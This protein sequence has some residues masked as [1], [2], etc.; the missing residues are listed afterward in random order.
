MTAGGEDDSLMHAFKNHLSVIIGFC[1]L[2][3]HDLPEDD[4][5]RADILEIR[6]AGQ[7]AIALL[8]ELSERMR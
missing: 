6:N 5:K 8:T 7:T 4:P 1:D 3:L 2:L